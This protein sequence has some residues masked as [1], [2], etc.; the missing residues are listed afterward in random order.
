MKTIKLIITLL[1]ISL[2]GCTSSKQELETGPVKLTLTNA[3]MNITKAEQNESLAKTVQFFICANDEVIH[4]KYF[5]GIT[6]LEMDIEYSSSVEY[7]VYALVNIREIPNPE[8]RFISDI[9]SDASSND[10]FAYSDQCSGTL[11]MAGSTKRKIENRCTVEVPVSRLID[12]I[13]VMNIH[14]QTGLE[15][16]V[17]RMFV[18][19]CPEYIRWDG[20]KFISDART[21]T[22][23]SD[24]SSDDWKK[25]YDEACVSYA[26]TGTVRDYW[27]TEF[28]S[29]PGMLS[30]EFRNSSSPLL[31]SGN[32]LFTG[33]SLYPIPEISSDGKYNVTLILEVTGPEGLPGWYNIPLSFPEPW[34]CE[35]DI[36]EL[37]LKSI[38]ASDPYGETSY[39][40]NGVDYKIGVWNKRDDIKITI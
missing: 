6:D 1:T 13:H 9:L 12:K 25:L 26:E 2:A 5:A 39:T 37:T 16:T 11:F 32:T 14:N 33:I 24:R 15:L 29:H 35:F 31:P 28:T 19:G 40:I 23:T 36:K 10:W 22:N 8:G 38:P 21:K 20:G 17:K 4:S 18:P 3:G 30:D 7:Y 27:S 34:N